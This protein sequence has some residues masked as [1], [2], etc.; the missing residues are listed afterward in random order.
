MKFMAFV[1]VVCLA[2]GGGVT[3]SHSATSAQS[4]YEVKGQEVYGGAID[5]FLAR[6]RYFRQNRIKVV[7]G[8]ECVSAC[9]FYTALLKD[10]L[11]CARP[12]TY[13]GFHWFT[14][15]AQGYTSDG[16]EVYVELG[17]LA[18]IRPIEYSQ[19]FNTYPRHVR[20][21]ILRRSPVGLPKPGKEL[22]I[23]AS[24]LGIPT[25]NPGL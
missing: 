15:V 20:Q 8:P 1:V 3:A 9:T 14:L 24:D 13:L 2:L 17:A 23:P 18:G 5:E 6:V 22:Y 10:N 12:G 21:E 7:I 19:Y 25:C 11:L 16:S 4:W